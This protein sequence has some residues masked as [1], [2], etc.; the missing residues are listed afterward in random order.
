YDGRS[1]VPCCVSFDAGTTVP[2]FSRNVNA[3]VDRRG[4]RAAHQRILCPSTLRAGD[5]TEP[6]GPGLEVSWIHENCLSFGRLRGNAYFELR[7]NRQGWNEVANYGPIDWTPSPSRYG[8][9][10]PLG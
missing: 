10:S 1:R 3:A 2:S 7:A 9:P 5:G 4:S 6:H 8:F